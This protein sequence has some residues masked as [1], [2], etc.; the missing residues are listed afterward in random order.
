MNTARPFT[1]LFAETPGLA[2]PVLSASLPQARVQWRRAGGA[3]SGSGTTSPVV[4]RARRAPGARRGHG[5]GRTLL[6]GAAGPGVRVSPRGLGAVTAALVRGPRR[7]GPGRR[8]GGASSTSSE[9]LKSI[10]ILQDAMEC[11]KDGISTG[12]QD[13]PGTTKSWPLGTLS[14]HERTVHFVQC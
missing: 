12:T 2:T 7:R 3:S 1:I 11:A 10:V 14:R 5:R 6:V 8:A 4:P 9:T 13:V